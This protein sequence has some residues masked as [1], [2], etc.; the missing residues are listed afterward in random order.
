MYFVTHIFNTVH[1]FLIFC[2]NISLFN[3]CYF[4]FAVSIFPSLHGLLSLWNVSE[5]VVALKCYKIP[6]ILVN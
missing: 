1:F 5:E 2:T 4:S 6:N 3:F